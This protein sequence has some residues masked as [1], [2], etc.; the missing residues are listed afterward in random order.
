MHL[1]LS[2][3]HGVANFCLYDFVVGDGGQTKWIE[4]CILAST[5]VKY[6]RVAK[7]IKQATDREVWFMTCTP[8]R[9]ED[10]PKKHVGIYSVRRREHRRLFVVLS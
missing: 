8:L 4:D 6:S 2:C 7:D 3:Q 9:P 1:A 5:C 10:S